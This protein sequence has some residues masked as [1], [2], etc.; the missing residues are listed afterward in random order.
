MTRIQEL[1][2]LITYHNNKYY[3]DESEISDDGYEALKDELL[4]L[5]PTNKLHSQVDAPNDGSRQWDKAKH[6]IH[7]GSQRKA[8][9]MAELRNTFI[10]KHPNEE[11]HVGLKYDGLSLS[12]DYIKTGDVGILTQATTRGEDGLEG[13]NIL[14]NVLKIPNVESYLK[15]CIASISVRAEIILP[16]SNFSTVNKIRKD[17]GEKI[18]SN[19][20]NAASGIIRNWDGDLCKYLEVRIYDVVIHDGNFIELETEKM[21]YLEHVF[22]KTSVDVGFVPKNVDELEKYYNLLT[23]EGREKLDFDIDGLVIKL[24]NIEYS[25]KQGMVDN[26]PKGQMA[27]KF[28]AERVK[29][30]INEVIWTVTKTGRVN[31]VALIEPVRIAGAMVKRATLNNLDEIERLGVTIGSEVMIERKGDI[32]PKVMEVINKKGKLNY[33]T[34]CPSCG[35]ETVIDR[36]Y[37]WCDNSSCEAQISS[38]V[39]YYVKTLKME[40][41]GPKLIETLCENKLI[42]NIADLYTFDKNLLIGVEGVGEKTIDNLKSELERTKKTTIIKMLVGINIDGLGNDNSKKLI[43]HFGDKIET[44]NKLFEL[45]ELSKVFSEKTAEL[46]YENS[47][48]LKS[49]IEQLK[50]IL[51]FQVLDTS[52][53]KIAGLKFCITGSLSMGRDTYVDL[54]EKQGGIYKSSVTSDLDYLVNNSTDDS[55]K[56]K[57][58][59]ELGKTI[60]TENQLK[61]MLNI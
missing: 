60:I 37:L 2:K 23:T 20:R 32:I 47:T 51:D 7:M 15:N 28:P 17:N 13:E 9:N 33:P 11:I 56:N 50:N 52:S 38:R 22:S 44:I 59:T 3:N 36:P 4:K 55:G 18:F 43:A 34:E 19:C 27:L 54:I 31:P 26:R 61:E 8:P 24:N 35:G 57:K 1:E 53:S 16:K 6:S 48:R 25:E 40:D 42:N 45:D 29:T 12:M 5:D 58:A 30:T 14:R 10:D 41:I 21:D 46:I 49:I 39:H